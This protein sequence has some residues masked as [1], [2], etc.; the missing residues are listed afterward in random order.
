MFVKTLQLLRKRLCYSESILLGKQDFREKMIFF[1]PWAAE[2]N[3][4][5]ANLLSRIER[6]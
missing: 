4:F 3:V 1:Q 6:L 2:D 5:G